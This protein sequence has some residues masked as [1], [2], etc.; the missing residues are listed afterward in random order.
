MTFQDLHDLLRGLLRRAEAPS[1]WK[2]SLNGEPA[3]GALLGLRWVGA[4]LTIRLMLGNVERKIQV[5]FLSAKPVVSVDGV[6]LPHAG[7]RVSLRSQLRRPVVLILE[8]RRL[9]LDGADRV[10]LEFPS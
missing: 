8:L 7:F 5:N 1:L 4:H 10:R 2:L 9:G 6:E 3:P